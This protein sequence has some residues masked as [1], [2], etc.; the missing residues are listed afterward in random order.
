VG[1]FSRSG[2]V[3]VALLTIALLTTPPEDWRMSDYGDEAGGRPWVYE[4]DSCRRTR[5]YERQ[6]GRPP[7]CPSG[8]GEMKIKRKP[9]GR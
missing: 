2:G 6:P 5:D 4:C 3:A 8:H 7:A 1:S 9:A